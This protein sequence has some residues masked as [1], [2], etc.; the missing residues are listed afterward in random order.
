MSSVGVV[1]TSKVGGELLENCLAAL[2][3]AIERSEHEFHVSVA[4][5]ET[6][7]ALK[8]ADE[9]RTEPSYAEVVNVSADMFAVEPEY[10]VI[11]HDDVILPEAFDFNKFVSIMEEN[12]TVGLISP[13][14]LHER[15]TV[16]YTFTLCTENHG[17]HML[18][19]FFVNWYK[20]H[21]VVNQQSFVD[22]VRSGFWFVRKS[23]F[24]ALKGLSTDY[25]P[26]Y[27]E[28]FD[29]CLRMRSELEKHV[30]YLPSQPVI[31]NT[32]TTQLE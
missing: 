32:H 3:G 14:Q 20:E 8:Y 10:L 6:Y 25:S 13:L 7:E 1:L 19:S 12:E 17:E 4:D 16:S 2:S 15:G 23:D 18:E 9:P 5:P 30:L 26:F 28:D 29:F 24:E 31:H 22:M 11:M 21:H 27:F